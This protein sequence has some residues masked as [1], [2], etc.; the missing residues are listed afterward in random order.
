MVGEEEKA[1]N[2]NQLSAVMADAHG[3]SA[4]I[5]SLLMQVIGLVILADL[6]MRGHTGHMRQL[7]QLLPSLARRITFS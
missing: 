7:R 2:I 1:I 3:P 6:A 4:V 5:S